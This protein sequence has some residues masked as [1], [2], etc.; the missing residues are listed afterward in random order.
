MYGKVEPDEWL[1]RRE[2]LRRL[3]ETMPWKQLGGR[4]DFSEQTL[5]WLGHAHDLIEEVSVLGDA[6]A[7]KLAQNRLNSAT[8]GSDA[9]LEVRSIFYRAL[10]KCERHSPASEFGGFIATGED[11]AAFSAIRE[12]TSTAKSG[13]FFVDP[14][15]DATLLT[16]FVIACPEGIN[17]RILADGNCYKPDLVSATNAWLTQYGSNRPLQVRIS[18]NRSLHDRAIFI[19]GEKAWAVSQS[20]K[21]IASRSPAV[22]TEPFGDLRVQ[23]INAYE[24][25]WNAG[26]DLSFIE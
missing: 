3:A 5:I 10:A 4:P 18:P 13:V 7:F 1:R 22:I 16:K 26:A 11:F 12:I 25:F 9:V 6:I 19:D 2:V 14:Y 23:K 17:I 20:F 8:F 21:D 15:A 24:E